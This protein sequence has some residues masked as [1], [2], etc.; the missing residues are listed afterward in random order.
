MLWIGEVVAPSTKDGMSLGCWDLP[1]Q[2]SLQKDIPGG[3]TEGGSR[4]GPTADLPPRG[5]RE[6]FRSVRPIFPEIG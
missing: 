5:F 6:P 2:G 3:E 1:A 4:V